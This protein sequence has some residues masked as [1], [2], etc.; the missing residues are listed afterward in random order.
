MR[1]TVSV[2]IGA[3]NG[4]IY[5]GVFDGE[6]LQLTQVHR[7]VNEP[8][9]IFHRLYWSIHQILSEI[10][11]GLLTAA[12][13]YPVVDSL[14]IDT[15]AVDFGLVDARGYLLDQPRHYRD[16]RTKGVLKHVDAIIPQRELFTRTGIQRMPINTL[17]Q[18][19][20]LQSENPQLL[21]ATDKLL[22]IPD[23]LNYCF[24]GEISAEFT[25]C[26]T[27]QLVN[28]TTGTWDVELIQKLRLPT[29]IFPSISKPGNILGPAS[30][31]P[32]LRSHTVLKR[33][34]VVQVAS[35][36]TASAVIAIPVTDRPYAFISSGTW[37]LLGTTVQHPIVNEKTLRLNFTNE[38]GLGHTRLLKNIMGLWLLQEV[39]RSFQQQ[40]LI[41]DVSS[42]LAQ[43]ETAPPFL[44]HFDPDHPHLLY[45]GD[46]PGKI[47][48]LCAQFGQSYPQSPGEIVRAILE[49]LALKY[50]LVLTQLEE[51]IGERVRV[52]HVVGG[53]S[54]NKLLCQM[55]ADALNRPV[56][57]G[58]AEASALGNAVVQLMALCELGNLR[59]VQDVVI[60]SSDTQIYEPCHPQKWDEVYAKF[61]GICE[62]IM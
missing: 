16:E 8:V 54:R 53:G 45:P 31:D 4:K 43:A 52:V 30:A 58:P 12:S 9:P 61:V 18:L 34:Q 37:S 27:T 35:H 3:S 5:R 59:D 1:I 2:D 39:Q 57:A 29:C 15:W 36:D 46:M 13:N 48:N 7:F 23:L 50:R 14:G 44:S 17:Y 62:P 25:N 49:S 26:T 19:V 6:R 32:I 28:V 22:L 24:T 38:G 42:L 11:R 33:T 56:I 47:R 55:T 60:A 51:V 40:G 20:A 41:S 10:R 21:A